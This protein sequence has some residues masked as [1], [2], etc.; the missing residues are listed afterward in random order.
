MKLLLLLS[1]VSLTLFL[2]NVYA[3]PVVSLDKSSYNYDES[4]KVSGK[5]DYQKDMFIIIQIRSPSDIVAIDQLF[6]SSSGSFSANF[7]AHGPKWKE[8]GTYTVLVTYSGQKIE[9]TFQYSNKPITAEKPQE[10]KQEQ[11][12]P[13]PEQ[14]PKPAISLKDFPDPNIAPQEYYDRYN[15]DLEYR[16]WF[17]STFAGYSIQDI[18][19]YTPTHIPDFPDPKHSPQYYIDRYDK[20]ERFRL[21]FDLQFPEKTIY[22]VVGVKQHVKA[23]IPEWIKNYAQ[24]WSANEIN[25]QRFIDGI[26]NLIREKI[27]LVEDGII[28]QDNV[29]GTIPSWFKKNADWYSKNLISDEDFLSGIQYLIERKIIVV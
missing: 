25:D 11:Q 18:V 10:K 16:R 26:A 2:A 12:T 7:E 20:E 8:T 28:K 15:T 4:I 14:K 5:V 21:W 27:I 23:A 13:Q 1:F 19:G 24:L 29:D 9:K 17:E 3:E 6:P 22:E